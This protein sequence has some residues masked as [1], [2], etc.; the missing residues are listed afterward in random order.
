[1]VAAKGSAMPKSLATLAV[2]WSCSFAPL[3]AANPA[4]KRP[5]YGPVEDLTWTQ[6]PIGPDASPVAG[7]FTK[8]KHVTLLRFPGKFK[9]PVHT[10]G[11]DYVGLVLSGSARHFIAGDPKTQKVLKAG[12]FW[13]M[14]AGLEHVS[15]CVSTE[16]CVFALIQDAKFDF[17]PVK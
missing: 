14:P 1:M 13:T 2:A 12:S 9:T 17:V 6:T 11:A 15:E 10:H 7:D 4:A 16:P 3:A 8:G 5:T